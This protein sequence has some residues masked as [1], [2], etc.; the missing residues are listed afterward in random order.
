MESLK[1]WPFLIRCL[2][3]SATE[4]ADSFDLKMRAFIITIVL[5]IMGFVLLYLVKGPEVTREE[6]H[7]Y[8]ILV[9]APAILFLAGLFLYHMFRAPYLIYVEEYAKAQTKV[10]VAEQIQRDVEDALKSANARIK[11]QR[12]EIINLKQDQAGKAGLSKS[13]HTT[14]LT[15]LTDG[16]R[17]VLKQKLGSYKGHSVLITLIGHAPQAEILFEQLQDIFKDS[18]WVVG[19]SQIGQMG[20]AGASPPTTSY[21]SG[22]DVA[23]PIVASVFSVFSS[24]GINL[25]FVPRAL[26]QGKADI[27]I[28]V[29]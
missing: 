8:L 18:G 15:A 17:F 11:E 7:K 19:I 14:S 6:L 26:Q 21:L 28:V 13:G 12:T 4:T 2:A 24:V 25:P 10:A 9:P 16:Q 20:V 1:F 23:A 29:Q 3:K 27:L 22:S 5:F